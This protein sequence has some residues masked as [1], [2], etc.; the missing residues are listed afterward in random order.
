MSSTSTPLWLFL[1]VY[2]KAQHL[3]YIDNMAGAKALYKYLSPIKLPE[4]FSKNILPELLYSYELQ[5]IEQL[6]VPAPDRLYI[7]NI[8]GVDK[9]VADRARARKQLEYSMIR[10]VLPRL[11]V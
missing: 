3:C 5:Q 2:S 4:N 7:E 8:A 6:L 10:E 11:N 9:W 1:Y